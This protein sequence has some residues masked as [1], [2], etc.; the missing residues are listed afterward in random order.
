M[1]EMRHPELAFSPP[2]GKL[3][4]PI[5]RDGVILRTELLG[6]LEAVP[7]NVPFVRLTAPAGYG[8]TTALSQWSTADSRQFAWVTLDQADSDPVR[9]AGQVAL[10]LHRIEP[11]DPAVFRALVAGDGLRHI[12]AL[13]HLLASLRDWSRPG[14][15]VLDDVHE[16]RSAEAVSF[17]R[18]L[19]A[20]LPEGF[21]IAMGSRSAPALGPAPGEDRYVEYGPDS[22]AFTEAEA[23]AVLVGAGVACSDDAVRALVRR[24]EGWPVG[25]Y[26][27]ALA[28]RAAPDAVEA[29]GGVSGDDPFVVD[30]FRDELLARESPEA[31]RFLLRTAPLGQMCGSLCDHVLGHNGSARRLTEAARRNLFVMPLDRHGEWFRYHRL[32]AEM[33]LSELRRREPGEELRVHRLAA[34]WYED[35]GRPEE[36]IGH[37]LASRHGPAAAELV[38]R[39]V[40]AFAAGGRLRTVRGWLE[41]LGDDGIAGYPPLAITAA[42]MWALEGDPQRAQRYLHAAE[43]GSFDGP[44][45]DGSTSLESAGTVL[46]AAMGSLGVERMLIDATA[47]VALEPPGSPWHAVAMG[48]L[49]VARALNGDPDRAAGELEVVARLGADALRPAAAAASAELSLLAADGDDWP[50]AE[51]AASRAVE[52]VET[53][54]LQDQLFSALA[55]VAAA[56]L[57]ARKDDQREAQRYA[58][59]ALRLYASPSPAAFPWLSAQ[60]AITL[61][62]TFLDLGDLTAARHWAEEARGQLTRLLSEGTLRDQLRQLSAELARGGG[63]V[64]VPSAMALSEAEMRVLRLLQTHLSLSEIGDELHTSRNTVKTQVAAVY[65]KL[66]CSTRTEAVRRGSDLELLRS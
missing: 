33:L 66:G 10:A 36:A 60:L 63:H 5:H 45:P 29:A 52:L 7:D 1:A 48:S 37:A 15:L 50:G 23:R 57:A 65:R 2:D 12:A 16:L 41:A 53:G 9:L 24:T 56:R 49:G 55:F 58:G 19:A 59:R 14:V 34:A 40:R 28:I 22:L 6:Q 18:A 54:G 44:L 46:H 4:P 47:A 32:V 3:E 8:K 61:G 39:H 11:L 21:H 42:W 38:N 20:G 62:R 27:A 30:Y 25:V 31:V 64:R 17:L 43:R 35:R 26:L 13:P 51:R